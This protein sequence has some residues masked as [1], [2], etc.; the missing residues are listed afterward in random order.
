MEAVTPLGGC[1]CETETTADPALTAVGDGSYNPAPICVGNPSL[2][3][4][5]QLFSPS[6]RGG[7]DVRLLFPLVRQFGLRIGGAARR[8]A[9]GAPD[10]VATRSVA[11]T[12]L[13]AL[14]LAAGLV[15]S[16][17]AQVRLPVPRMIHPI[18][19]RADSAQSWREPKQD[20]WILHGN[21]VI[22]QGPTM[23]RGRSAVVF[24]HRGRYGERLNRATVYLEGNV[25]ILCE[26]KGGQTTRLTDDQWSGLFE[27]TSPLQFETPASSGEPRRKPDVYRRAMHRQTDGEPDIIKPAQFTLPSGDGVIPEGTQLP[28][29]MRRLRGSPR[30]SAPVQGTYFPDEAS[31]EWIGVVDSGVNLVIDG[32][33]NYGTIDLSADRIVVWTAGGDSPNLIG[34]TVQDENTPLEIYMEGN[35]I[36]RQGERVIHCERMYYDVNSEVGVILQA[37][38]LTPVQNFMGLMRLKADLVQQTGPDQFFLTNAFITSSRLGSPG[39]RVASGNIYFEDRQEPVVNFFTGEPVLDPLTGE[40]LVEHHRRATSYNNLLYIERVPVFYWPVMS[41]NLDRPEFYIRRLGFKNDNIFGNQI[42]TTWDT[43]QLLGIS[44][45]PQGS[46]WTVSADYLSD[47]GLGVGTRYSYAS[48]G[49]L[50]IPGPYAGLIDAWG[51]HDTGVDRLGADRFSLTPEETNRAR[52]LARHRWIL[53][54]DFQLTGEFGWISDRNFLEQYFE[55]EWDTFKDATT[56]V[57]LKRVR[58]NTSWSV[59]GD[60]RLNEFF[61]QTEGVRGE[62]FWLGQSLLGDRVTWFEHTKIGYEEFRVA[63]TPV[64]PADVAAFAPLPWEGAA[65][66]E[67]FAT[68]HEIDLP[69]RAGPFKVVPYA[70]GEFAHWGEDL[71][72]G[73]R[74]RLYGQVGVRASVPMWSVNPAVENNLL[75]VHGIAHKVVFEVD[76]S[77]SDANADLTDFPLYDPLDDDAQEHFRRRFQFTTFFGATPLMF[78]ERFYALRSGLAGSVTSPSTEIAD[79]LM[80]IRTSIHQR[81]QTK[82]GLPGQRRTVDWMV[83]DTHAVFFP[84]DT[85]DN[86]GE[87]IGLVGHDFRWHVGDQVTLFSSSLLDTFAG[88]ESIV[89]GGAQLIHNPRGALFIGFNSYDGPFESEVLLFSYSYFMTEKWLSSFSSG[90]DFGNNMNI[91]QFFSFTRMGESFFVSVGFG[92]D[93]S[94]DNVSLNLA[95]QPRF[96]PTVRLGGL[97]GGGPPGTGI[98]GLQ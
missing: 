89:R 65:G 49:L 80:A 72:G 27:S 8:S 77:F 81:W 59:T 93:A 70:L 4:S 85:R 48:T 68:R 57:E 35:V 40:P 2:L 37:E 23:A 46:D 29:G 92:V 15:G 26:N 95:I 9:R 6:P 60:V 71:A 1:V 58:D 20:V 67:R 75:N 34:S 32:V 28:P 38:I 76:A 18:I 55:N 25:E 91:G 16:A 11:Q 88:G 63:S 96:L 61:T 64:D 21:C 39:Y 62:H 33:R 42:L 7:K 97:V 43:F 79:D 12:L 84:E 14:V 19:V 13:P 3:R 41:T 22:R 50:G 47:R 52:L 73:S 90:Y 87:P 44:N 83:L 82:R 45:P 31:G 74:D 94:K 56:G 86:F 36:F 24:V 53:P 30:S 98:G 69:L 66:G 5:L 51:I 78:D 10:G 17:R 54:N